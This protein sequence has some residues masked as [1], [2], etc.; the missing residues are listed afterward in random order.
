MPQGIIETFLNVSFNCLILISKYF[1]CKFQNHLMISKLKQ[2]LLSD[3]FE[4]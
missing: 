1:P 3:I 4:M 2:T